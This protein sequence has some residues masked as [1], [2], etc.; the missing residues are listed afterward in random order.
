MAVISSTTA[1]ASGT[2]KFGPAR[3]GDYAIVALPAGSRYP[4]AG[5]WD[6]LAQLAAQGERVTLGELDE[7]LVDLRV[8]TE[9]R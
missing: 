3:Q 8:V 4:Q 6:R 1:A 2:F 7:R 9:R 5:E